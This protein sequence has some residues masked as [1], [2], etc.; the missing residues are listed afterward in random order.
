MTIGLQP[1]PQK[2]ARPQKP[3]PTTFVSRRWLE[4]QGKGCLCSPPN[5]HESWWS[6]LRVIRLI[7]RGVVSASVVVVEG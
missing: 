6:S 4:L 1:H 5:S 2:V 7:G 3:T